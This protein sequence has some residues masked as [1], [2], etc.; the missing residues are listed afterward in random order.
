VKFN[1]IGI[2]KRLILSEKFE[3][4]KKLLRPL[5]NSGSGE[6]QLILGYLYYGGDPKT[7]AE[8][9][10][11]WLRKSARR[12]VPEAMAYLAMT[13]FKTGGWSS[14][15]ESKRALALTVEAAKMGAAEA[16]RS[17]ACSYANG[18]M[19]QPDVKQTMYWDEQAAKQGLAESQNDLALMLLYGENGESDVATAIYWYEKSASK[20]HNVPYAEWAAEALVR[21]YEGEPDPSYANSEKSE[22][23]RT[24]AEY[25]TSVEFRPHPDW[26][27]E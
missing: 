1:R 11:Q 8:E 4:A 14:E 5:A 23:W 15:P 9:S 12:K 3:Q 10:A 27:Y 21:I 6:A 22:Y 7:T 24:R 13:N 26:F 2:A 18:T 19:V 17:L 20:D 25:L 16:Q